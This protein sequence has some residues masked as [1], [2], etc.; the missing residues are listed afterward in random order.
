MQSPFLS[1]TVTLE[2]L[3]KTL[4]TRWE[5]HYRVTTLN[6]PASKVDFRIRVHGA[7]HLM[8]ELK[9]STLPIDFIM[10]EG[11]GVA[12]L[13]TL[14]KTV[15]FA[16]Y[17]SA[18]A[19]GDLMLYTDPQWLEAEGKNSLADSPA[20]KR[21]MSHLPKAAIWHEYGKG[22][23]VV[24]LLQP[25]LDEST[26]TTSYLPVMKQAYDRLLGDF[27]KPYASVVNLKDA[28][29][30]TDQYSHFSYK[31]IIGL[32]P[33]GIGAAIALPAMEKATVDEAGETRND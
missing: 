18:S 1:E 12:N 19:E 21:L 7:G 32:M 8:T 6:T 10:Q 25:A 11:Q 26:A 29:I 4:S 15:D 17:A 33:L 5:G 16:L 3:L 31:Q 2:S 9:A 22:F 23:D 24:K 30:T 13:S 27:H 28:N 14:F 20:F